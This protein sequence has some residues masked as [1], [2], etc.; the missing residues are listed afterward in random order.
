M[1]GACSGVLR[2]HNPSACRHLLLEFH[3]HEV[4]EVEVDTRE[5]DLGL[6]LL[7]T[8]TLLGQLCETGSPDYI[9]RYISA[10]RL[11]KAY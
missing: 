9:T 3:D 4:V 10:S 8:I 2:P 7:N 1:W 6:R 11:S 5:D